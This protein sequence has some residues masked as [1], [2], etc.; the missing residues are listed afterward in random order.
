MKISFITT[1]FNE[2]KTIEKFLDSLFSQ[3]LL[4]YEIV[5][6]DGGNDNTSEKI[7]KY[8]TFAKKKKIVF[9]YIHKIGN[10]SVGRNEA[11]KNATGDII[12][13]SDSGNILDKKWIENIVKPFKDKSVDVVAG[14]YK[15]R[16]KNI[17]QKCVIPYALVMPDK[18]N[19]DDFLPATRSVAFTKSVWKKVGGFDEKLSHNEDYVFA[20]RLKDNGAKIVFAKDAIVYWLPR[21]T[22]KEAFIMMFRFAFGDAESQMSRDKVIL[23]F[24]RYLFYVYLAALFVLIKSPFILLLLGGLFVS[25]IGWSIKKNYRYV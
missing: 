15:G 24:A 8:I 22:F 1:I 13:C 2:E 23:V 4:P 6:T 3:S 16:P 17:F 25:Y 9:K 7:K 12:V 5:I 21:N 20:N 14:Y 11:V 18:V 19:P 10:R